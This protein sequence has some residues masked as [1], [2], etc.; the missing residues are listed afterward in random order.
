M[1]RTQR[2]TTQLSFLEPRIRWSDLPPDTRQ[3]IVDLLAQLLVQAH[4]S[5]TGDTVASA[6]VHQVSDPAL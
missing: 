2:S 1:K 6:E 3:K 4:P 5:P